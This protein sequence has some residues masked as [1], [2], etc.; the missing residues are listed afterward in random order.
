[1]NKIYFMDRYALYCINGSSIEMVK[2]QEYTDY[3]RMLMDGEI[4]GK[5]G[6]LNE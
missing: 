2:E 6:T 4:I 5:G 1:M 3:D